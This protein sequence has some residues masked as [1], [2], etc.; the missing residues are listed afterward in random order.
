MKS[1]TKRAPFA[2]PAHYDI[3]FGSEEVG[4]VTY[5][6]WRHVLNVFCPFFDTPNCSRSKLNVC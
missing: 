5:L 1:V 2:A 3:I 6:C 4:N